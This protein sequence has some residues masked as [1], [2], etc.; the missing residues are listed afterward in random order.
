MKEIVKGLKD[1]FGSHRQAAFALDYT[2]RQYLTIRRKI[3]AGEEI[4][5]RIEAYL[6][7]RSQE[8]GVNIYSGISV[9]GRKVQ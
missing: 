5:P 2:D 4:N 8:L 1:R 6:R 7:C 9:N 3:N